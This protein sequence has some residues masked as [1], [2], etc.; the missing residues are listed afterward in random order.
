VSFQDWVQYFIEGFPVGCVYALVATGLVL[1][2]KTSGVFNLAFGAQAFLSAAVMYEM[3]EGEILG[4]GPQPMWL[5]LVVSVFIVAPLVG[6]LF[7][8]ALFRFMRNSSWVTKLVV[9]LGLF[10]ALPEIV[11]ALLSSA[12]RASRPRSASTASSASPP[13]T[14]SRW[15]SATT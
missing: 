14:T 1:T 15:R 7:D 12:R 8:R 10:V 13:R 6:L 3:R 2:Y 5:C 4:I 11:K 9:S